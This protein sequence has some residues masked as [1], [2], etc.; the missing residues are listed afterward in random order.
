MN[1]IFQGGHRP[2]VNGGQ[3]VQHNQGVG[4]HNCYN[5]D[6]GFK[7][8]QAH[9]ATSA[10]DS[11]EKVDA[12]KCHPKARLAV[13]DEI[14]GWI[15][16]LTVT[17]I[18]WM[19]WLNGAAG[20]GKS[21][22]ARSIV[23]LCL[24]QNIPV[25]RFF[26]FRTDPTR[27]NI[28]PVV[29]TLVHQ[30][31]QQLPSLLAIIIPKIQSDPL[32][33]RKS[34]ETQLAY[35]VIEPLR[36]LHRECPM[37]TNVVLM[38]DGV[39]EC[40]NSG[41][42]TD[43]VRFIASFLSTRDIPVIAFFCLLQLALDDHYLPDNDIR[44]FLTEKFAEIKTTHPF[45]DNLD[46]DWPDTAHVGEIVTK[47]SGQFIYASVVI[48]FLSS[49]RQHPAQQLEIIRGLRPVGKLTPYAQL[50]ALYRHIFSQVENL[51]Q[52]C[53]I[54]AYYIFGGTGHLADIE[55]IFS[56]CFDTILADLTSI[57]NYN[58]VK[59]TIYLSHASLP[60][61]L[62]DSIRSQCYYLDKRSWCTRLSIKI[63]E[64]I[65][66]GPGIIDERM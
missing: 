37:K 29:A 34:L 4:V 66:R 10:F 1:V 63:F 43:L 2:D 32:I 58:S 48:K 50:D 42:Q 36:Q 60:D 3:S 22:I 40:D 13:L 21:A 38:F 31:I 16:L 24:S 61:F 23:A 6:D 59:K 12:P 49:P 33:F 14:M 47:S 19:L 52:A 62:L 56:I 8:L 18:Q 41:N 26:F 46:K 15:L 51:D 53:L 5:A 39:D 9:V 65:A 17:R 45:S 30:L 54:L 35:L 7:H 57:V 44:L 27:N 20:A 25:A 28:Q 64:K 55:P 11:A